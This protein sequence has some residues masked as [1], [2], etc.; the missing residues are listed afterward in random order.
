MYSLAEKG[1]FEYASDGDLIGEVELLHESNRITD[2]I[3]VKTSYMYRISNES[4]IQLLKD[5]P[6]ESYVIINKSILK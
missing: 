6:T 4:F 2:L 3:A 1:A 5:F